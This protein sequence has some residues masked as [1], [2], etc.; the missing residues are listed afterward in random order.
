MRLLDQSN[1]SLQI[2]IKGLEYHS[3]LAHMQEFV[4][5]LKMEAGNLAELEQFER[6]VNKYRE[7]EYIQRERVCD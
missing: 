6:A 7:A 5:L 4:A 3:D 1:E 2:A